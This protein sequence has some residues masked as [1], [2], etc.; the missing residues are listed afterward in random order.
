MTLTYRDRGTS[1]TQL[2]VLCGDLV[3]ANVYR[4]ALSLAASQAPYRCWTFSAGPPGFEHHGKAATREIACLAVERNW[5]AWLATAGLTQ[6]RGYP[7]MP[8]RSA[9]FG[10]SVS[11]FNLFNF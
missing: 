7:S 4:A 3:I 1:G 11:I 5:E 8:V 9:R 6:L 10:Q 2:E